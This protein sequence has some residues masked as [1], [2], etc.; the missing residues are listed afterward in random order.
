M[1]GEEDGVWEERESL[2]GLLRTDREGGD[3]HGEPTG[4][5]C[6]LDGEETRRR[7]ADAGLSAVVRRCGS[8]AGAQCV[9]QA[10]GGAVQHWC[11]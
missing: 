2:Q 4:G 5:G 9:W 3:G 1:G 7:R 11:A 6:W 10:P 8:R